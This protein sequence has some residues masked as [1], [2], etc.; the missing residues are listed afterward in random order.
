MSIKPDSLRGDCFVVN[1]AM[2]QPR[3]ANE[4][5]N[6]ILWTRL[7]ARIAGHYNAVIVMLETR[8][9]APVLTS[10]I[11][12]SVRKSVRELNTSPFRRSS[13]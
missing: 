1:K 11:G 13:V 8:T 12:P 6:F 2:L 9:S 4:K 7:V 5:S 3:P 10:W